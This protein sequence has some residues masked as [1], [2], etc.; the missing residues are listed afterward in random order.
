MLVPIPPSKSKRILLPE[1][2]TVK[3]NAWFIVR[4]SSRLPKSVYNQLKPL[5]ALELKSIIILLFAPITAPNTVPPTICKPVVS[6]K[7][8]VPAV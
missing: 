5:A 7:V 3:S 6:L 4:V 8:R 2:L 1:G